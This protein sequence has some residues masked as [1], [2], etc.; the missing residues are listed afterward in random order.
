MCYLSSS[1]KPDMSC[2][3]VSRMLSF[4]GD[5]RV[6]QGAASVLRYLGLAMLRE[7]E[8]Q[9]ACGPRPSWDLARSF[10]IHVETSKP[11]AAWSLQGVHTA[12]QE[13]WMPGGG[14]LMSGKT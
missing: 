4:W 1:Q 8:E 6:A 3:L 2:S 5:W 12:P 14:K 7:K 10:Q 13:T 11:E 9:E